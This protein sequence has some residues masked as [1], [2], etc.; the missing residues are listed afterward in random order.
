MVGTS[1]TPSASYERLLEA[2]DVAAA[3][4]I[5]DFGLLAVQPLLE[6]DLLAEIGLGNRNSSLVAKAMYDIE[7]DKT[8]F[9]DSGKPLDELVHWERYSK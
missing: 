2:N 1:V 6:Q 8:G 5:T 7:D 4:R 3:E 9:D